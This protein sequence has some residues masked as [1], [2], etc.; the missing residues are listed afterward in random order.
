MDKI[1]K[2]FKRIS[3]KDKDAILEAV[4]KLSDDNLRNEL[5]I[6]KIEDTDFYRIRKG[7]YRIIF[8]YQNSTP[9]VD[10]ITIRNEKTYDV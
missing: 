1:R 3:A 7:R 10:S 9:F 5:D 8:H 6:K 2:L 4:R